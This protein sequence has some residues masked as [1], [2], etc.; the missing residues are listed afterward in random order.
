LSERLL[1]VVLVATSAVF[2]SSA[3][4]FVRMLDYD[5]FTVAGYR[6]LF[7]SLFMWALVVAL[8]RR[9]ANTF[10]WPGWLAVVL[11]AAS[12]VG[13]VGA[14]KLTTVA[15]VVAIYATL[16]LAAGAIGWLAIG[17][18]V[19]RRVV[20]ASAAAIAGVLLVVGA[21]PGLT[22]A[23]GNASALFTTLTFAAL[24]V[25]SR[26][27]PTLD[28]MLVNAVGTLVVGVAM[29]P[30]MHAPALP[31]TDIA[32]FAAFG[33]TTT[34]G[35]YVLFLIGSRYIPSAEAGLIGLV[36]VPLA[37]LWVW[38]A[39]GETP[40]PSVL[41]GGAVILGATCWAVWPRRTLRPA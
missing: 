38:L 37:P 32:L 2:W 34:G 7:G 19:E 8:P 33:L 12:A 4:L 24:V 11:T 30:L 15:N 9:R 28:T 22:N 40:A 31:A 13:Y 27:W 16:P 36:D 20:L 29:L 3:G 10:G 35:A 25:M 41:A 17:E 23:A 14:L 6:A 1:G 39:M 5:V 21:S 26:R 18:R